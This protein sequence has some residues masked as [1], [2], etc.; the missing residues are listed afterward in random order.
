MRGSIEMVTA[1]VLLGAVSCSPGPTTDQYGSSDFS[2]SPSQYSAEYAGRAGTPN[3][4]DRRFVYYA[5]LTGQAE[6]DDGN[7]AQQKAQSA[8]VR[9]F[10]LQMAA[11]HTAANRELSQLALQMVGIQPP[12]N[13]SDPN[14]AAM[15]RQLASLQGEA[16]DRAY[17]AGQV[18]DH[19]NAITLY[20]QEAT[21]GNQPNLQ[22]YAA[23]TLPMLQQHL[24]AAQRIDA[25]M[26]AQPPQSSELLR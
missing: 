20:R 1:L 13:G 16:F 18:R 14:E 3:D 2:A 23:E 4:Q 21:E 12:N 11:D 19:E 6:I 26:R 15:R 5:T 10:G 7:M 8:S 24:Q 22:R 17:I 9:N 25:E